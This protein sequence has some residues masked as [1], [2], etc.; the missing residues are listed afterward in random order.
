MKTFVQYFIENQL[1]EADELISEST[2]ASEDLSRK[3]SLERHMREKHLVRFIDKFPN[4][5]HEDMENAFRD[6]VRKVLKEKPD[7]E[8]SAEKIFAKSMEESLSEIP[9]RKRH[10]KKSL[11]CVKLI[12]SPSGESIPD[13]IQRAEK[14]LTGKEKKVL[15]MCSQGK[16]VRLIAKETGMSHPTVW[17]T[18]NSAIDKIRMSHGIRPRYKDV[19]KNKA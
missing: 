13:M 6:A 8:R 2:L 16:S 18:L 9:K 10:I 12:K 7:S 15:G 11:S 4:V 17:R 14:I 19:R 3:S 1:R 5:Q